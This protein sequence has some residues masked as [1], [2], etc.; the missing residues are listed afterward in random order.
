[1]EELGDPVEHW[2]ST[3]NN[4]VSLLPESL[5]H[6]AQQGGEVPEGAPANKV[7]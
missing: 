6:Q 5:S 1:M 3:T 2:R 4:I 7:T